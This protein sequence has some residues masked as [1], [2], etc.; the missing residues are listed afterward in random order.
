LLQIAELPSRVAAALLSL[1][2]SA[3]YDLE[4]LKKVWQ[5]QLRLFLVEQEHFLTLDDF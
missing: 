1:M 5:S 2:T 3:I 4:S